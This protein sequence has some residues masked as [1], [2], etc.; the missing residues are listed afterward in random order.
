MN[1]LPF[2][3]HPIRHPHQPQSQATNQLN[4]LKKWRKFYSSNVKVA[5]FKN[6]VSAGVLNNRMKF[7]PSVFLFWFQKWRGLQDIGNICRELCLSSS[8]WAKLTSELF[9]LQPSS[10]KKHHLKPNLSFD[11]VLLKAPG[12]TPEIPTRVFLTWQE[13]ESSLL[14]LWRVAKMSLNR[15]KASV[16]L[17]AANAR[18]S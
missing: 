17:S 6:L 16:F 3:F 10:T 11:C 12:F 9:L 14:I 5:C 7:Y 1:S 18:H 15:R 8:I 4:F 2:K 13:G